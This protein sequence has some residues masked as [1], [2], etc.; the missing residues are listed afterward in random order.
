[1]THTMTSQNIVLFSWD[2]LYE[3][4]VVLVFVHS[5]MFYAKSHQLN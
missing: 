4:L 1:M 2:T 5:L 3:H